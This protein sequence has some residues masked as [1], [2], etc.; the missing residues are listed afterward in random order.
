MKL[1]IG[2]LDPEFDKL[3]MFTI[4]V[5]TQI[6]PHHWWLIR[7]TLMVVFGFFASKF[8]EVVGT[9]KSLCRLSGVD[10]QKSWG[11]LNLTSWWV[12]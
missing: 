9:Y 11:H 6:W 2:C 3:V 8:W 1:L 5:R 7:V 4:G 12:Q 10:N